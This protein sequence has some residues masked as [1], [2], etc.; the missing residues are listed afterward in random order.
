MSVKATQELGWIGVGN[1]GSR[2]AAR[3]L[4]AGY[5][6]AV[7]GSGRRDLT[8]WVQQTGA[9]LA[10]GPQEVAGNS[11]VFFSTI[12]NGSILTE[13]A[14]KLEAQDL[15]GKIW[16]D[17]STVDAASSQEAAKRVEQA[18]GQFL[19]APVT[20]STHFAAEGTLGIM[21]S[22]PRAAFERCLPYLQILGT[23]QTYLGPGEEARAMKI[24]INMLLGNVLQAWGEALTLGEKLGLPWETMIDLIADSAAAAPIIQYK[25]DT[26]KARDFHPTST[27]YN[28]HKDMVLATQLAQSADASLP[29]TAL[30]QQMYN[31]LMAMGLSGWDNTAVVV[32]NEAM[33]GLAAPGPRRDKPQ[34]HTG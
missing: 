20:G 2:M 10:A 34:T 19:R 12:P 28:M 17:M 5:S 13:L 21:V 4:Q 26:M 9:T 8:G 6:L 32:I 24:I 25:S 18:G 23:R 29:L 30:T 31:A 3:L 33:N 16:V 14:K 1:M 27:G 22:G 15:S 11:Q 7:C